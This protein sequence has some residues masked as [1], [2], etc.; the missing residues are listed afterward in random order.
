MAKRE[1]PLFVFDKNRWHSQGE[2]DFIICTDID[3]SFVARVDY[4]TEPEM[5]SDTVKRSSIN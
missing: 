5:V 4:V 2:C 3:N 1:I